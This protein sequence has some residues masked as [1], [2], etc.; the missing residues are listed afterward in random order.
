[1]AKSARATGFLAGFGFAD[2]A[3][4]GDFALTE[5]GGDSTLSGI[6]FFSGPRNG[7]HLA[8]EDAFTERDYPL[9]DLLGGLPHSEDLARGQSDNGIRRDIDMLDQI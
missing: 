4:I 3:L 6:V 2:F 8:F 5:D 9:N 1:V 7:S